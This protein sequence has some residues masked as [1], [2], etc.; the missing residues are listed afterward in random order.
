MN[1]FINTFLPYENVE[2]M[3]TWT[4]SRPNFI[5][6]SYVVELF[7]KQ[8]SVIRRSVL[9]T[10]NRVF[11]SE[12][13]ASSRIETEG[14]LNSLKSVH[15]YSRF[16]KRTER[17][18]LMRAKDY[19]QLDNQLAFLGDIVDRCFVQGNGFLVTAALSS[20]VS[21][22]TNRQVKCYSRTLISWLWPCVADNQQNGGIVVQ[23]LA[24]AYNVQQHSSINVAPF[25]L[26]LMRH[27]SRPLK[28]LFL[29]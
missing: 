7:R 12:T 9:H 27:A 20:Y 28:F 3:R 16:S 4:A 13:I 29:L 6:E 2:W 15:S 23:P 10:I 19:A 1:Q 21:L 11:I 25:F 26:T 17:L 18:G 24:Y 22:Q 5:H 8:F 14:V